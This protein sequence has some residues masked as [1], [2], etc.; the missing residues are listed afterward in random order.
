MWEK[1]LYSVPYIGSLSILLPMLIGGVYLKEYS[2]TL[3]YFYLYIVLSGITE[4]TLIYLSVNSIQ[5]HFLFNI[6]SLIELTLI[7]RFL[8]LINKEN[9]FHFIAFLIFS[10]CWIAI[11][12]YDGIALINSKIFLLKSIFITIIGYIAL[13]N[14]FKEISYSYITKDPIFILLFGVSFYAISSF[15]IFGLSDYLIFHPDF[16]N[17]FLLINGTINL[18]TNITY[19]YA[20]L[21]PIIYKT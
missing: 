5:N 4:I 3:K 16:F 7:V 21:C 17:T 2:S 1:T 15:A 8:S 10:I 20:Y 12:I 18:I 19:L 9:R 11:V 6:F 14:Y 13:V